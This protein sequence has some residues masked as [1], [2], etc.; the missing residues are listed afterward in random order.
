MDS[1][2]EALDELAEGLEEEEMEGCPD[3]PQDPLGEEDSQ[4]IGNAT[5]DGNDRLLLSYFTQCLEGEFTQLYFMQEHNDP[6][7]GIR[8]IAYRA[9][10]GLKISSGLSTLNT[11][12]CASTVNL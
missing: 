1:G 6:N 4:A 2:N 11:A 10:Y 8:E 7:S 5:T 12:K 3:I 9:Q